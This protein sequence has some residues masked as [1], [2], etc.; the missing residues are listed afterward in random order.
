MQP[1]TNK[2]CGKPQIAY[3]DPLLQENCL[4]FVLIQN[5]H[6][7]SRIAET[8][9]QFEVTTILRDPGTQTVYL[10]QPPTAS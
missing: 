5:T 3:F 7:N 8:L 10:C 9:S 4:T 2:N 1:S 6:D